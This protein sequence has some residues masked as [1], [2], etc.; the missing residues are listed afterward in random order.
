MVDVF[1]G[2][3][4]EGRA[5]DHARNVVP[6]AFREAITESIAVDLF[7]AAV[8]LMARLSA[9]EPAGCVA[10]EILAVEL[11]GQAEMWLD[12]EHNK[13]I[14]DEPGRE[15][16]VSKL[17]DIFELFQDDDVLDMFEMEEPADAALVGHDLIAQQLGVADQRL[18]AWFL[19][20]GGITRTGY[21]HDRP[22]D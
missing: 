3:V 18:E 13:G 22:I 15:Q 19:P 11:L 7:A 1:R 2:A 10:E 21:L 9:G 20:F 5:V 14:I 17:T 16:A 4:I 12:M 8:A 6:E